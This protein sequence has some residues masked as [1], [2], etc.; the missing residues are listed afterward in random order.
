MR[1]LGRA[2]D[3]RIA[4]LKNQVSNLLWKGEIT[5]TYAR[6]K[7]VQKLA[8]KYI[9]PDTDCTDSNDILFM[10]ASVLYETS[11]DKETHTQIENRIKEYEEKLDELITDYET[12]DDWLT[13]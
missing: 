3:K 2:T 7:E 1:K 13:F 12:E 11:G 6:A 4:L 9:H 10:A 5:T 8:E